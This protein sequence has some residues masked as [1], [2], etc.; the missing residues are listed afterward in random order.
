MA[1]A[2]RRGQEDSKHWSAMKARGI[3]NS[4]L[5][6]SFWN[7]KAPGQSTTSGFEVIDPEVLPPSLPG[8]PGM[9]IRRPRSAKLR[10]KSTRG[11]VGIL[12]NLEGAVGAD[13][14]FLWPEAIRSRASEKR[15]AALDMGAAGEYSRCGF[16]G[17]RLLGSA[18]LIVSFVEGPFTEFTAAEVKW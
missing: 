17:L 18:K 6:L 3:P 8:P 13:I 12:T 14:R 4:S 9:L 2:N 5:G 1:W 10:L 11:S 15:G 7:A 16:L